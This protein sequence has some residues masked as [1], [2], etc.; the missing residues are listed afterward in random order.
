MAIWVL[1]VLAG[2]FSAGTAEAQ[3]PPLLTETETRITT[4]LADQFD[5]A[6]SGNV[7]VYSDLRGSDADVYYYD[8]ATQSEH[9]V[10]SAV[11][12]QQLNDVSNGRIVYTDYRTFD[13]LVYDTASGTTTNIT[14]AI[15]SVALNPS[16]GGTIVAWEDQRGAPM[17]IWATDLATGDVRQ[18][19]STPLSGIRSAIA[20]DV[21]VWDECGGGFC[22]VFAYDR[23]TGTTTQVTNTS[24][25]LERDADVSGRR[26]VYS[27]LRDGEQDVYLYDLDSGPRA[28]TRASGSPAEPEHQR[29]LRRV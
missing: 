26:V 13:V 27:G 16:I 21:I 1:A 19:T 24:T 10:T 5:P 11:G 12:N 2:A 3:A 22:D 8:I 6:L 23:V 20:D 14:S 7:I 17:E 9:R 15:D 4:S 28:P 29:R 25:G 18:V